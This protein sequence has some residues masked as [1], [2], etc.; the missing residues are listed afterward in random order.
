MRN[1][2]LFITHMYPKVCPGL[3]ELCPFLVTHVYHI[4]YLYNVRTRIQVTAEEL[5]MTLH[6]NDLHVF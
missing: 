5:H 2:I 4:Q 6:V 1:I 3:E